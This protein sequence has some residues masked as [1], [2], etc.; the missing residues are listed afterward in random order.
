MPASRMLR[1]VVL[2][3]FVSLT[4]TYT[5]VV[6][7]PWFVLA[8]TG[9]TARM[10]LVLAC[11][12]FPAL[13]LGVPAGGVVAALG[14]R[15]ALVLADCLRAPLLASI[16]VLH[17]TGG[18]SFPVL[19]VLV[20]VVGVFTVPYSAASSS[21]LPDI[22]GEDESEV[23]R[24]TAALQVAMQTTRIVGPTIAGILIP[25]VG[26]PSL[27]LIDGASYALSA[28]VLATFVRVGHARPRSER[29]RGLLVGVRHIRGDALLS[30]ILF[31]ALAAHLSLAALFASLPA[32]AFDEFGSAR[33]AG[34]LF[35]A[36]AAGSVL[37]SFAAMS[38]ARR[39]KPMRLG[40]IGFS[41]MSLPIWLLTASTVLPVAVIALFLFGIGSPLAVSPISALLTMRAPANIRPQV[42]SAFFAIT[43]AGVPFGALFTGVAMDRVG[44]RTTY[45]GIAAMLTI[46]TFLLA[47]CVRRLGAAPEVAAA[48][49]AS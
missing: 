10:G 6:A 16:P 48:A 40:V 15:R 24:A 19:L 42:M 1:A 46:G 22:V 41:V 3:R 7:L 20:T 38:L 14:S 34:V 18:L 49:T 29:G 11:Q 44:F 32:L 47:F 4:G 36:D 26:A 8:T 23:A 17:W 2:S 27:L 5:T 45:A 39:V 12:T 35:S 9:S 13:V 28:L 43:S 30:A 37:G 33:T 21:L 25:F 31:A